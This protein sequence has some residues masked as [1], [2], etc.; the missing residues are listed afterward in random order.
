[1][2]KQLVH[3]LLPGLLLAATGCKKSAGET[4]P[5]TPVDTIVQAQA[6][7]AIDLGTARQTIEGFGGASVWLG[8]LT[9]AYMNTL[10][11]NANSNQLGLSVL[12]VRIDPSGSSAWAPELSN[13]QKA[14]AHGAIVMATPW[15]PPASMKT[16]GN[17]IG[18]SLS[19][20][21]YA[22]YAAYL[23]S[24]ADYMSSGGAPL[25]AISVQNEPD[26]NVTYESCS[27]TA[28]QLLD[29]M[30][31]YAAGV[32][33]TKIIAAE[34][35]HFDTTLTNPIL[36]DAVAA[37]NLSI[38]GGHIY[39]GGLANYALAAAKGKEVWMTEHLDTST[40]WIGALN[41]A[42]EINDCMTVG[43]YSVYLWWYLKRFYGP[44]DDNGNPT[45]R[46]YVMGQFAKYIRPGFQRVNATYSPTSNVYLG[47]Y[48][49][50]AN[51]VIMAVNMGAS[52]V[53]QSFTLSGGTVPASF[54]PH[55]TDATRSIST[56][57][58]IAVASGGF[59]YVLPAQSVTSFVS[60]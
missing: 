53:N 11:G 39:G 50:G 40:T 8:A 36:D 9:D 24:F 18:G 21:S 4:S 27:W 57:T 16:N 25:Y 14:I 34:S 1:M 26:I 42:K 3:F 45:K 43:N 44:M 15:T 28:P 29:F 6:A 52:A 20:T 22:A 38:V 46:G 17:I 60:N 58:N 13:A 23:K 35:F 19:A 47:A 12:R 7:G 41:T 31:N 49:S 5:A 55:I 33:S 54:T 30:K 59:S 2:K 37:A 51:V 10:Y 56:E 32:G 48:K